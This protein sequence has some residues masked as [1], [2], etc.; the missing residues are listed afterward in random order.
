MS[1]QTCARC[2]SNN[3]SF[4][5]LQSEWVETRSKGQ[6]AQIFLWVLAL[7]TSFISLLFPGARPWQKTHTRFKGRRT[8]WLCKNCG[9]RGWLAA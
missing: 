2:D 1:P 9:E 4:K 6:G 8:E 7:C 5:T 3:I